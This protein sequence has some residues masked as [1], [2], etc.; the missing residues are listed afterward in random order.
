MSAFHRQGKFIKP[1]VIREKK[2]DNEAVKTLLKN[3]GIEPEKEESMKQE[4]SKKSKGHKTKRGSLLK[5]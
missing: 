3:T 5:K 4:D 2:T 1:S